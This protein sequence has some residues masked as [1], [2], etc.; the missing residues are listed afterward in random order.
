MR[1]SGGKVKHIPGLQFEGLSDHEVVQDA[2]IQT[3]FV[4]GFSL[5]ES[6]PDLPTSPAASLKQEHVVGVDM[7]THSG[8]FGGKT[9]HHIVFAPIRKKGEAVKKVGHVRDVS[10]HLLHQ[11]GPVA[12]AQTFEGAFGQRAVP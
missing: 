5:A 11:D 9:Y 10:V 7:S 12:I 3:L 8:I 6:F 1:N 4:S 2:D